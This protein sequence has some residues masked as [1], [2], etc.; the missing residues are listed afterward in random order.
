MTDKIYR[1]DIEDQIRA[2]AEKQTRTAGSYRIAG[3]VSL[4]TAL[5][6]LNLSEAVALLSSE[7][8]KAAIELGVS[9][10]AL[11]IE[12]DWSG[13]SSYITGARLETDQ[14]L[15]DRVQYET[16]RE[17][18]RLRQIKQNKINEAYQKKLR[19]KKLEAELEALKK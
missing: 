4:N 8:D 2:S 5:K 13:E 3:R 16:D 7:F 19:I 14:E 12:K 18:N 15:E 17:V 9:V 1:K 11:R 10:E 6:N